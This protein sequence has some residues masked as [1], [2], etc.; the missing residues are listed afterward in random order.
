MK[1]LLFGSIMVAILMTEVGAAPVVDTDFYQAGN[2]SAVTFNITNPDATYNSGVFKFDDILMPVAQ[3]VKD[4]NAAYSGNSLTEI[5]S[6]W[7]IGIEPEE[8]YLGWSAD[9]NGSNLDLTNDGGR[10]M[11]EWLKTSVDPAQDEFAF[12]VYFFGQLD[13]DN[14]GTYEGIEQLVQLDSTV[15]DGFTGVSQSG[16]TTYSTDVNQVGV[17]PE[18][19]TMTMLG[20]AGLLIA[21]KR[22]F[23]A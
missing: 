13:F 23:F 14:S 4:N 22:R 21:A 15:T 17:V 19:A 3:A 10:N 11:D 6:E 16:L 18:P 7:T 5:M 8:V 12:T 2:N 1:K 20:L 9:R